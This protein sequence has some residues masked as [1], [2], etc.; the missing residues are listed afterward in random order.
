[1]NIDLEF[2]YIKYVNFVN[3]DLEFKYLK[4]VNFMKY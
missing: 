4:Y 1:M 3:I 2:K